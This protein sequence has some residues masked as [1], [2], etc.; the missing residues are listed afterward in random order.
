MNSSGRPFITSTTNFHRNTTITITGAPP[1]LDDHHSSINRISTSSAGIDLNK[2]SSHVI[3][4]I[5]SS[6]CNN[7]LSLKSYLCHR[8]TEFP[9]TK[10]L[11]S[12][13]TRSNHISTFNPTSCN[14]S[15]N[16]RTR[17]HHSQQTMASLRLQPRLQSDCVIHPKH[18][19]LH[20]QTRT[21][22][23]LPTKTP[24]NCNTNSQH[25]RSSWLL[26]HT[27]ITSD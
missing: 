17:K 8:E 21:F 7:K 15:S 22:S 12:S 14:L 26:H 5:N 19:R 20:R 24:T 13:V 2:P 4:I 27:S 10:L 16:H 18:H 11:S 3:T 1:P 9:H 23:G 25:K 6:T